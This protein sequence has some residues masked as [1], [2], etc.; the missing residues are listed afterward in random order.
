[1]MLGI[2]TIVYQFSNHRILSLA[3][4]ELLLKYERES[5]SNV[6][7]TKLNKDQDNDQSHRFSMN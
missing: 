5:L 7:E 1:M 4:L 6:Y 2:I 3:K